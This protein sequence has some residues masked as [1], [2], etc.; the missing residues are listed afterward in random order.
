M[1]GDFD[2]LELCLAC[3][4]GLE[5]SMLG[6]PGGMTRAEAGMVK[7]GSRALHEEGTLAG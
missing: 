7:G 5:Y 4:G 6:C 3:A 1:P 2:W